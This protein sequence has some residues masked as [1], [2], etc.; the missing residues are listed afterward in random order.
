M[1]KAKVCIICTEAYPYFKGEGSGGSELQ[2]SLL[3]KELVRRDHEV[4][5]IVFGKTNKHFEKIDG[6]NLH[7]P[8]YNKKKGWTHFFP[9]NFFKFMLLLNKINADIYIQ[10][11]GPLTTPL[12][13]FL[14][15]IFVFSVSDDASVSSQLKISSINDIKFIFHIIGIKLSKCVSCQTEQQ[16]RFLKSNSSKKS[17]VIKNIYVPSLIKPAKNLRSIL[18]VGRI[19]GIKSPELY[20]E[21]AKTLPNYTFKMIGGLSYGDEACYNKIKEKAEKIDN[22]TFIGSVPHNEIYQYFA[23]ASLFINTSSSEGFPNTFLESWANHTPIVSLNFDPDEI[24]ANN[25]LGLYS[26]NFHELKESTQK[27][28]E[29]DDLREKMGVNC[30][31]YVDKEHNLQKIVNEYENLFQNLITNNR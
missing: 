17:V 28:M 6:V 3:A 21:L 19:I 2:M 4:H 13:K 15:K 31:N 18:W 5:F 29:D 10:R 8:Y 25:N 7:I 26:K 30:F 23:E 24:I 27:L 14:N 9:N 12:I 11:A 20:L 16:Q 22:L 1:K